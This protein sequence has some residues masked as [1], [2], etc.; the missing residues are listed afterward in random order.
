[1]ITKREKKTLL[2]FALVFFVVY[3]YI[4]LTELQKKDTVGFITNMSGMSM[5]VGLIIYWT[6][7]LGEKKIGTN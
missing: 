3:T 4:G 5:I 2:F 1:M 7:Q 6:E